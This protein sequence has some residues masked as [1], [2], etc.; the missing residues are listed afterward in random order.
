MSPE[1]GL[2]MGKVYEAEGKKDDA[3]T[4]YEQALKVTGS[5]PLTETYTDM[6]SEMEARVAA[7]KAAGA[8]EKP[9]PKAQ[10]GGDE[11]AALRTY[12]IPSPLDGKY[13]SADFL[14]LLGDNRAED[15]RFLKGDESL[16]KAAPALAAATYRAPLPEGSKAKVL[17]RGI[18][19]CTTGSKTCLLVLL[20]PESARMDN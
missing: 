17:R 6:K 4:A 11:V 15:V 9:G 13:A 5:R 18:V 2:H 20:P 10:Q 16:Q 12:T 7:L 8:H 14:L 3:L 1:G 19:A